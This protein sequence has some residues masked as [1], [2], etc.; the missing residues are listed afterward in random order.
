[1]ASEKQVTQYALLEFEKPVL[2]VPD[3]LVIGSKLDTDVH[4]TACRLAFHGHLVSPLEDKLYA[5]TV[6]PRIRAFKVKSREG[7]VE[8]VASETCVIAKNMFKKE[9]DMRVFAGMKVR[10][11]SGE[12]GTIDGSFGQS[13][14]VKVHIPEGLSEETKLR[15][16][17]LSKKKAGCDATHAEP[18]RVLLT[19]KKYVFDA[20][21]KI[22]Q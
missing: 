2:A 10:L 18:V 1:M 4:T 3:C 19:F 13:G 11:S 15:L 9:T 5:V 6:L 20:S 21:K 7:V 8:R 17:Y 22:V 16:S 14:K 12:A